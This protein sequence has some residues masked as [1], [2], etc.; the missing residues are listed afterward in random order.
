MSRRTRGTGGATLRLLAC[1]GLLVLA[2]RLLPA[3]S[4]PLPSVAV[5]LSPA[6]AAN[7]PPPSD[8]ELLLR[9]GRAAVAADDPVVE[10]R[11]LKLARYLEV[12]GTAEHA[13]DEL[14]ATARAL[15]L[16]GEDL[17]LRRYLVEAARLALERPSASDAPDEDAIRAYHAAH[18]ER[19]T[20]APRVRATHVY[21]SAARR[22]AHLERDAARVLD[23]LRTS[24][25]SPGDPS[26]LGDPFVRGATIAG[27]E[28]A[29]ARGF[30]AG[31]AREVAALPAGGWHGPIASPYG[32]HLVRV[33]ERAP[34]RLAPL[35][36]V[37]GRVV[38][39][40]L[41][42]RGEARARERLARLRCAPGDDPRC[43]ADLAP[44]S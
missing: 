20:S 41:R 34:A 38:H 5:A 6:E 27:S 4:P 36:E 26:T 9:A 11:L 17:V 7:G 28:D 13:D 10:A 43:T 8:D 14:I 21:L 29:L 32:L 35:D 2:T 25:A 39:A 12:G 24:G 18:A 3:A 15:G 37:R 31:F 1:G 42:E 16:G 22:G 40:L 44:G 23:Q 33:E 19:F 30:G